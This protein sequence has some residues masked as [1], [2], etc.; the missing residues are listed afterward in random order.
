[1]LG[2]STVQF[3][4]RTAVMTVM[5]VIAAYTTQAVVT[6]TGFRRVGATGMALIAGA[7][8]LLTRV[9]AHGSYWRDIFLALL[10]FGAGLGTAFVASQIAAL[11]GVADEE[12]GLAAGLV[13]S[14]FNIGGA[15]GIAVLST[16]AVSRA[17]DPLAGTGREGEI[18]PLTEGFQAAFAVAVAIAAL[19][20][21]LALT[22]FRPRSPIESETRSTAPDPRPLEEQCG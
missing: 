20:V 11:A 9:S 16:V 3:G 13:D 22:L 5:S 8:L 1:V 18:Q 19:G 2:Y 17:G 15:L 21:L 4:L 12:S 14:S 6:R 7:F 10:I